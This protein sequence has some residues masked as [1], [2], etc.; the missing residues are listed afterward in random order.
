MNASKLFQPLQISTMKL[1]NAT[2][3]APMSLGYESS[4]GCVNERMQEYWLERARGG[5]GCIILDALSVDP[6]V[7]YLGNTLCFRNEEAIASYK[8]FTD[9][10]HE[11]GACII[12]QIT[13]PGPESISAFMGIPPL[14]S[15]VYVNSM[16]QKTREVKLEELPHIIEL[17]AN[18]S[19]QA[20]QAG[21]DGIELHCA[22]AYMLLGSFLSPMRNKRCD[23]YGGSLDNRARLLFEVIDAIKAACGKDF[24]I[25]LR[26]SGDEKDAQGNTV[27]DMCYLVPKLI[28]HG[29]DAFE[30]S[31]GTQYERPN[32]IIP[33]HG[34]HE[35]VNVA[36]AE[37][38]RRVSSVPVIVVG[39]ILDPCMAM[40]LVDKGTVDGIVFGRALLA[41]AAL[42]KK[43]HEER[44]DEIAP[45]TGCVIGCVGEQTKRHPAS[46]VINPAC[47]K[48]LEMKLVPAQVKKKVAVAGGGIAGM[49]AART[50]ALRGHAVTLFEKSEHLGG[51]ILLACV[52][53]FKQPVSKWIVYLEHEL[54]RL[55]VDV[56]RSTEFTKAMADAYDAVI[57]ATG[58][59]EA[60]PPIP[61]L[62]QHGIGAWE[63]LRN[64]QLILG[65]NVLVVGGGMVGCEVCEHL[66]HNKRG[67]LYL[68]MIEMTDEI[69]A[70]MVVNERVLLMDRLQKEHVQLMTGTKLLSVDEHTVVMEV[71]GEQI[72]RHDFTHV[73]YATGSR[74]DTALTQ[75]L[76]DMEQVSVVG[77]AASVAQ[78]LE[79]VRDA[80]LAAMAI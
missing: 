64:D 20:K 76:S 47:G 32:K 37:K 12:P 9:K 39:K 67:P 59:K 35:G 31:G 72:T 1:R 11:A 19:L 50:L 6:S 22:H 80:T 15:S 62:A 7:P 69:A 61:G 23:A 55:S 3:M 30:I 4:D 54:S 51:Q 24:P 68:T 18:A 36:E 53:P 65:G 26:M 42:V 70:G 79:A 44:F 48:E 58:A 63:L 10:I 14:A 74:S 13:H 40:D 33:S 29:I 17:Y 75:E 25:I 60:L 46:C 8:A 16:G 28:E 73:V 66:L 77:D 38:I 41:D 43:A 5:V 45:C 49:A 27:E 78:A 71:H 34:E 57:V 52:P 21:F 2:F 56:R